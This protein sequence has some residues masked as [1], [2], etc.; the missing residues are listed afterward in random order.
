MSF[1]EILASLPGLT[2]D[3][4][5]VVMATCQQLA[6]VKRSGEPDRRRRKPSK[7]TSSTKSLSVGKEASVHAGEPAYRAYKAASNTFHKLLKEVPGK[8]KSIKQFESAL[9]KGEIPPEKR[10][11]LVGAARS[12]VDTQASWF[13]RQTELKPEPSAARPQPNRDSDG[14]FSPQTTSAGEEHKA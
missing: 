12:L 6:V 9:S 5:S 1:T 10:E 14:F 13:R 7:K 3:Q 2:A 8:L 4:L 11:P